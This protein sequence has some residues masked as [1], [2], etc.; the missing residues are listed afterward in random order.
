M[1]WEDEFTAT[2]GVSSKGLRDFWFIFG[3][4]AALIGVL[5]GMVKGVDYLFVYLHTL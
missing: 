2:E 3:M 4:Y 5:I 1:A